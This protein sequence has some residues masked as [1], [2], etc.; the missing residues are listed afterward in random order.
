MLAPTPRIPVIDADA[1]RSSRRSDLIAFARQLGSAARTIGFFA[2]ADHGVSSDLISA[3]FAQSRGFFAQSPA[4]KNAVGMERSPAYRGYARFGAER[5]DPD[6]PGDAKESFNLGTELPPDDPDIL[7]GTPFFGLNQWPELDGFRTTMLDYFAAMRTLSLALMRAFALDLGLADEH[8]FATCFDR[9]LATLRLLRYPPHPGA[10]DGTL[11]G[12]APHTDYGILTLLA[13]DDAAGLEVRTREGTWISV[14][15]MPGTLIC[16]IGDALMRWSN[17]V[18]VS[19]P[20]RVVNA[21]GRERHS[22]AFFADP[23]P[24]ARIAC[25]PSCASETRPAKYP[26][27]AYAA[28]QRERYDATYGPA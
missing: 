13:Q 24:D 7:A 12:A 21:S 8:Y 25:F 28:Y 9:P 17:D 1:L 3:A 16:N 6:R 18:Y 27:I 11:Y 20:H 5:L 22:I 14:E 26:P 23:N 4:A 19:T 15:P 10:F 2:V